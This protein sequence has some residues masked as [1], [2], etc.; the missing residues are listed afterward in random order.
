MACRALLLALELIEGSVKKQY[1]IFS[2]SLS[3]MQALKKPHPDHPLVGEILSW[4]T[5]ITV[6]LELSIF[7]A[8][9]LVI[10]AFL[11]M[12]KWMILQSWQ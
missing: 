7:S 8:G 10:S 6:H 9:F 2:D 4:L 3:A 12:S 1:M 11:V 5:N